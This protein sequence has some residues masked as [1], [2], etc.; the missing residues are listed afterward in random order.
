MGIEPETYK[1]LHWPSHSWK[2]RF[3]SYWDFFWCFT[4][5]PWFTIFIHLSQIMS[6]W[7]IA[8]WSLLLWKVAWGHEL[9]SRRAII[10]SRKEKCGS[11]RGDPKLFFPRADKNHLLLLLRSDIYCG[12]SAL[13]NQPWEKG[14]SNTPFTRDIRAEHFDHH[15]S[16]WTITI[17]GER[18]RRWNHNHTQFKKSLLIYL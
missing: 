2:C 8:E 5:F 9:R 6:K 18:R 4:I 11:H 7:Y 17:R 10:I 3:E 15:Y 13:R 12:N 14:A 1:L 16:H